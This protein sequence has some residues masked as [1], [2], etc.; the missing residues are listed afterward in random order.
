[1]DVMKRRSYVSIVTA[2]LIPLVSASL[3]VTQ[4]SPPPLLHR[5]RG[6]QRRFQRPAGIRE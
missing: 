1:M 5:R 6:W 2:D 4:A 3:P